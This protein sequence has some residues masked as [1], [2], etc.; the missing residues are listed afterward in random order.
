MKIPRD[1]V[2][3][4]YLL[5]FGYYAILA[6]LL[7]PEPSY[8]GLLRYGTVPTLF[9]SLPYVGPLGV[10]AAALYLGSYEEPP[11]AGVIL[12]SRMGLRIA[13]LLA[14]LTPYVTLAFSVA[15]ASADRGFLLFLP[16]AG[17]AILLYALGLLSARFVRFPTLRHFLAWSGGAALIG[18]TGYYLPRANPFSATAAAAGVG[19]VWISGSEPFS[20]LPAVVLPLIGGGIITAV[21]VRWKR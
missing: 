5:L 3:R 11:T 6:L 21:V 10:L 12:L 16:T 15:G 18:V 4:T 8:Y 20:L 19:T 17:W 14:L 13:T 2:N 1:R 7:W 9:S